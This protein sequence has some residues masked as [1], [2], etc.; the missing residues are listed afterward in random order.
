MPTLESRR[1]FL[2]KLSLLVGGTAVLGSMA[3]LTG[4]L[5]PMEKKICSLMWFSEQSVTILLNHYN[6]EPQSILERLAQNKQKVIKQALPK[7]RSKEQER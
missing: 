4:C 2:K 6:G 7:T 5:S 3:M 1:D